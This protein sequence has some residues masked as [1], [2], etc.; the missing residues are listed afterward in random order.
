MKLTPQKDFKIVSMM[1]GMLLFPSVLTLLRVERPGTLVLPDNPSPLGYTWS[2]LLFIVP[3]VTILAWL[4]LN[5]DKKFLKKSFWLTIATL[6]PIGFLLDI[7]LGNLFFNF[8]NHEATI[9]FNLPGYDLETQKWLW[10]LPI[11][12]FIFYG[13]GFMA[14]LLLYIWCDEF[15]FGAYNLPDYH[16]ETKALEKIVA[17][18]PRSAILGLT[19]VVLGIIYKKFFQH[20]YNEGFP[21]YFIFLTLVSIVPSCAFFKATFRFINWR[22]FSFT[23]FFLLLVSLM[24]EATLG[25]PYQWWT[26][27]YSQM[28][29]ITIG[30]WGN[31]PIEAALLWMAVT[32]TTVIIYEVI[33]IWLHSGRRAREAFFGKG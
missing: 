17:F 28:L 2:L 9:Q 25:V 22:A 6:A 12:E 15:W 10:D 24:W 33:K 19:L 8:P 3:I 13:S 20:Q 7:F 18:H 21:G 14:I 23:F 31:L 1:I 4:H 30:A 16:G 32:F 26:Y 27:N 5:H 11:E 29:G